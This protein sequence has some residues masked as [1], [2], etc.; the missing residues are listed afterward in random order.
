LF[1]SFGP[2]RPSHGIGYGFDPPPLVR[3]G[4]R[5]IFGPHVPGFRPLSQGFII[6]PPQRKRRIIRRRL[7]NTH[8]GFWSDRIV[9][10]RFVKFI[11]G[12][13]ANENPF[14]ASNSRFF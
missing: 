2:I 4:S 9:D 3:N 7:G 6:H 1:L 8:C 10:K 5:L 12:K 11:F 13:E 14:P